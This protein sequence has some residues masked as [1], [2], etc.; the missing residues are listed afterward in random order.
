M[1]SPPS[2]PKTVCGGWLSKRVAGRTAVAGKP[3]T[4][5]ADDLDESG[6]RIVEA[7]LVIVPSRQQ[8]GAVGQR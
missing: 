3:R 5:T 4:C 2:G 6:L 7:Q 8:Q 1:Y